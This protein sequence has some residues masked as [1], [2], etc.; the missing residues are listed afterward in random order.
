MG[1]AR[2][3]HEWDRVETL[4][5][6]ALELR[7]GR[8]PAP[9]TLANLR[10]LQDLVS[11]ERQAGAWTVLGAEPLDA[12]ACDVLACTLAPELSP[13]IAH[14]YR[15]L[16]GAAADP[17]AT[18]DTVQDL[19][20][21]EP[22]ELPALY[23]TV[24]ED[25]PLRRAGLI[26]AVEGGPFARLRPAPGVADQLMGRAVRPAPPPG[27]MA[28]RGIATWDDLVLPPAQTAMLRE[29]LAYLRYRDVVV[30]QWGGDPGYGPIALFSGAS[31][32]GK[33]MAASVLAGELDWPL[34]CVDLGRLV[35]K[36]IGETEK[37]LN[38]LFDAAHR[39]PMILQFDEAD[40]LFSKRGEVR[41]ARDRY[42]NMEVSHLLA[43]IEAH[44]GPC[45]LTTNLR[46]QMDPA[47]ARRF[48]VVIDFP[49]PDRAARRL[50][51]QRLL[52]PRAPL[53][54]CVDLD[55]VAE[56]ADISGGG[57]RNAATH[58]AVLAASDG[59]KALEI[60]H[61][62]R[63]VWRELGKEGRPVAAGE[64]GLLGAHLDR[65]SS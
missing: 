17:Y 16:Q 31:G 19:L 60:G 42:A 51:W 45:I 62:A 43:R 5:G 4:A 48:H 50:L 57:I 47:F 30:D 39:Q 24:D 61:I 37:N 54:P 65:R 52:P 58:A 38:A 44:T 8:K 14:L 1:F 13:R 64:I 7:Q 33:T 26:R 49:R 11:A 63:A 15:A 55:L 29:F 46:D 2:L 6:C 40:S 25:G 34:Y 3:S 27:T 41:E 23:D 9:D 28:V 36:Y 22:A 10:A 21:L 32:T 59:G 12:L 56:A 53:G 20:S 18:L 35:S